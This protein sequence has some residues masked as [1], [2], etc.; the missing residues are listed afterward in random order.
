MQSLNAR[1]LLPAS[2]AIIKFYLKGRLK[3]FQT[4]LMGLDGNDEEINVYF[5][6][7]NI[8]NRRICLHTGSRERTGGRSELYGRGIKH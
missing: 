3:I 2:I 5:I 6:D 7:T 1:R 8:C 4:T